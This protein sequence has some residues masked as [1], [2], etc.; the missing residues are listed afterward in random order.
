VGFHINV[1]L[2]ALKWVTTASIN[3]FYSLSDQCHYISYTGDYSIIKSTMAGGG[4]DK[5]FFCNLI[6]NTIT[7]F[8]T[9]TS[10]FA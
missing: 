5:P 8:E 2:K 10:V 4:G 7:N 1:S 6:Y 3:I 9:H